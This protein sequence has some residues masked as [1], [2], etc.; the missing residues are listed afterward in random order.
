M[1]HLCK[2]HWRLRRVAY[3]AFRTCF[4][5][6]AKQLEARQ[7]NEVEA[8]LNTTRRKEQQQQNENKKKKCDPHGNPLG[9]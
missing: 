2:G 1:R 3:F 6:N 9:N 8:L 5:N 7:V 4:I